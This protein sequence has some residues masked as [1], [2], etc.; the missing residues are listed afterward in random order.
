MAAMIAIAEPIFV[1]NLTCI[2]QYLKSQNNDCN[3]SARFVAVG[4]MLLLLA[5]SLLAT[6]NFAR[7]ECREQKRRSLLSANRAQDAVAGRSPRTLILTVDVRLA[8]SF[9]LLFER[10]SLD[11][12]APRCVYCLNVISIEGSLDMKMRIR[13]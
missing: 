6:P 12:S 2:L 7:R 5:S 10:V 11:V 9:A 1:E 4:A 3:H 13:I 8:E